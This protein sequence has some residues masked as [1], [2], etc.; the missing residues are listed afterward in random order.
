M[1]TFGK[2]FQNCTDKKNVFKIEKLFS[3]F[4]SVVDWATTSTKLSRFDD[5]IDGQRLQDQV[6]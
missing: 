6:S 2:P 3:Q 4:K 1:N 5:G